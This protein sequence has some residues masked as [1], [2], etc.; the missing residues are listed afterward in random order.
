MGTATSL[1]YSAEPMKLARRGPG[2]A[3]AKLGFGERAYQK[4]WVLSRLFLR[5][6]WMMPP[7]SRPDYSACKAA[8]NAM[9]SS[10]AKA[11][12][13][14]GVTV[15]TVLPGTI[16]SARLDTRFREVALE[17]GLAEDMGSDRASRAAS[18]RRGARWPRR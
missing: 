5:R 14:D 9:T 18:I 12:A 8:M 10:M 13:A 2:P 6:G 16:R 1:D 3:K 11:V 7:A 4:P 17:H 15:N